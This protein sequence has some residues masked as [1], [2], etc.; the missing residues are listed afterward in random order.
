METTVVKKTWTEKELMA[1]PNNGNK[2]ELINGEL[3]MGPIGIEHEDIGA[4]LLAGSDI[5]NGED[6]FT[7]F[8]LPVSELFVEL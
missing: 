8:T 4:R 1:L 2:Y 5:L 7:E 6:I 3:I